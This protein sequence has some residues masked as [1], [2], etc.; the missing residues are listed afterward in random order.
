MS[1]AATTVVKGAKFG[2]KV[3]GF[4]KQAILSQQWSRD[5][6]QCDGVARHCQHGDCSITRDQGA[7]YP[8][9]RVKAREGTGIVA[10]NISPFSYFHRRAPTALFSGPWPADPEPSIHE[11]RSATPR[12]GHQKRRQSWHGANHSFSPCLF[13]PCSSL[14][15]CKMSGVEKQEVRP[16]EEHEEEHEDDD[17]EEE[18][19]A[20]GAG[21]KANRAEKKARKAIAKLGLKPVPGALK[22]IVKKQKQ[23]LFVVNSPDVY[24]NASGDSYVIFGEAKVEDPSASEAARRAA[25]F[26][27]MGGMG[28]GAD[29]AAMMKAMGGAEGEEGAEAADSGAA[30]SGASAGGV[31]EKDIKLVMDQANCKREDAIKALKKNNSDIVSASEFWC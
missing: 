26:G 16:E 30:D 17:V 25:S 28:G 12:G 1:L 8:R 7:R 9:E 11:W 10:R 24:K 3:L 20:G 22:V 19:G 13:S 21:S 23:I 15:F 31:E 27:G 14:I 2:V 5:E 6:Q 29:M 18:E 4:H